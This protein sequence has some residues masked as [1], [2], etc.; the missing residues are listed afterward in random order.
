MAP[1]VKRKVVPL[2]PGTK[3]ARR[4]VVNEMAE[5]VYEMQLNGNRSKGYGSVSKMV[6][7]A[8]RI[9]PWVDDVKIYNSLK[10]IKIRKAK[11][12]KGTNAA[13]VLQECNIVD[14]DNLRK[15]AV[16]R[17][18]GQTNSVILK[19]KEKRKKA[20]SEVASRYSD[21]KK[22]NGGRISNGSFERI[23]DD[24][25]DDFNIPK[26]DFEVVKETVLSRIK[27]KSLTVDKRGVK[28][29]METVE[30]VI[31]QFARG[32]RKLGN[33]SRLEKELSLRLLSSEERQSRK[34][35]K[36]SSNR[37]MGKIIG[38]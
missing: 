2:S 21:E 23:R 32:N 37:D 31:Y 35:F 16:G 38:V 1:N 24:V 20:I 27:R 4:K 10:Y 36:P 25:L 11:E 6:S 34:K 8:Q 14:E 5:K 33:Q 29:P 19:V 7:D 9:Y 22:R 18:K 12:N 3:R 17:P 15:K 28:S 13:Q 26:E 30:P